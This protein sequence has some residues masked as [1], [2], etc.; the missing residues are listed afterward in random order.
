MLGSALRKKR[1]NINVSNIFHTFVNAYIL[2]LIVWKRLH[3]Y[4]F[5]SK[6]GNINGFNDFE[7]KKSEL[8]AHKRWYYHIS[9][10]LCYKF[11]KIFISK[12]IC[13]QVH[14]ISCL[15]LLTISQYAEEIVA[16][17]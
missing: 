6:R 15:R 14:K 12:R 13:E 8:D 5:F 4:L 9:N 17:L 10:I 1:G 16:T 2:L 11:E 3:F 7:P